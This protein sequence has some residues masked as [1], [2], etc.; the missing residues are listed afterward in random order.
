M[1]MEVGKDGYCWSNFDVSCNFIKHSLT[2]WGVFRR[3]DYGGTFSVG[4]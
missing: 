2:F 3:I 1:V 4:D